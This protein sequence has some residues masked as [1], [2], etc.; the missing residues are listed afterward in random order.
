MPKEKD[1]SSKDEPKTLSYE[2]LL[3]QL[4]DPNL[5]QAAAA[6]VGMQVI[7]T[8]DATKAK[9]RERPSF[10]IPEDAELA[11]V[12]K[13]LNKVLTDFGGFLEGTLEDKLDAIKG[14]FTKKD[15]ELERIKVQ[16]FVAK[17]GEE[18]FRKVLPV[19]DTLYK[20]SKD[21]EDSYEKACKAMDF[22]P[23]KKAS[24]KPE[25]GEEKSEK[26]SSVKTAEGAGVD[27]DDLKVEVKD[28]R[29][30]AKQNLDKLIAELGS[31]IATDE[32]VL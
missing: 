22:T 27:K 17:V 26:V 28:T 5:L 12:I 4:K 16:K 30:A 24:K 21:L 15:E 18:N 25:R 7:T 31:D 8:T 29:D 6:R 11:D 10:S 23:S 9:K 32:D 13:A 1:G 2:E 19:M 20:A 14:E 3:A